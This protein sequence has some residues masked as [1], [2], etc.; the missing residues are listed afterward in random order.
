MNCLYHKQREI[1][2]ETY[3][4]E[5]FRTPKTKKRF[6]KEPERNS[7]NLSVEFQIS[8]EAREQWGTFNT[9][10]IIANMNFYHLQTRSNVLKQRLSSYSW[11][12]SNGILLHMF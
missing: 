3:N 12:S 7:N 8:Q 9:G 11:P 10:E 5:K 1:C 2:T 6:E 4:T